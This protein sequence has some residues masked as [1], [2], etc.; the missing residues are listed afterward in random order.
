MLL[1]FPLQ[2]R[3]WDM[4]MGGSWCGYAGATSD[5]P[6]H[7][8]IRDEHHPSLFRNDTFR[9]LHIVLSV[10]RLRG[11]GWRGIHCVGRHDHLEEI[12]NLLTPVG[13]VCGATR[14]RDAVEP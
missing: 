5:V 1:G 6:H 2:G 12:A 9:L 4:T 8:A 10:R 14:E 7:Q 13:L 11:C 3:L